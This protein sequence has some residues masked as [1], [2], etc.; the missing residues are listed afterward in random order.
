[1]P[2]NT[3]SLEEL[4]AKLNRNPE[5]RAARQQQEQYFEI[6]DDIMQ[7]RKRLGLTQQQ[8]AEKM[9]SHQSSVSRLESGAHAISLEKLILIAEALDAKVKIV[10]NEVGSYGEAM[11]NGFFRFSSV[12][13]SSS[14]N[15]PV[16]QVRTPKLSYNQVATG[17][18][19]L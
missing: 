17:E 18:E 16:S 2:E 5:F 1:M 8:L 9:G 4:L 19:A 11:A 7:L 6:I 15:I 14:E 13:N 3:T 10:P 12:G